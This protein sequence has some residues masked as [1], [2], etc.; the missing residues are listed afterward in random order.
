MFFILD[1]SCQLL[2]LRLCR[3]RP[4]LLGLL[5][6]FLLPLLIP[7]LLL[8]L[9]LLRLLLLR[10]L[11]LPLLLILPGAVLLLPFLLILLRGNPSSS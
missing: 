8:P 5:R 6:R 10:L 9:L 7:L 2:C 4:R 11:L 3:L 1:V